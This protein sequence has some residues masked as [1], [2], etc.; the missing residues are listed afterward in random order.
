MGISSINAESCGIEDLTG[1]E[2]FKLLTQLNVSNYDDTPQENWNKI[3]TLDVSGNP[4]LRTLHCSNNQLSTINVASNSDLRNLD[5]T[6]NCLTQLDVTNSPNLSLLLCSENQLTE[7]DVTQNL[8][9]DQ[10]YCEYNQLTSIDVTNH[11][12]MMIFNCNDNQLTSLDLTGCDQLFQLYYYNNKIKSQA[13]EEMVNKLPTPPN[14]GY[15]VVVDLDNNIEQN[16]ITSSQVATAR[17]KGWSVEAISGD[18]FV[19]YD[20]IE[21]SVIPGDA[22]EDTRVDVLDI[23]TMINYILGSNPSPFN[24]DNANVNGDNDVNVM[25]VTAV[26]N[27]I[28]GVK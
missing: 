9:L 28:L 1:I 26:I 6:G 18:D 10:L 5:C 11:S 23:T 4:Y 20:G 2:H 3:T 21:S 27:I 19:Q 8:L 7:L 14:G 22:N 24:F 17:A 12:K 16:E 13:M 25:D 15:M